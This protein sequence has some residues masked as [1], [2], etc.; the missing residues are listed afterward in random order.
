MRQLLQRNSFQ[1]SSRGTPRSSAITRSGSSAATSVTKSHSPL[2]A[3][4]ATISRASSRTWISRR[5][6]VRGVKPRLTSFRSWVCRGGSMWISCCCISRRSVSTMSALMQVP[7]SE[8]KS[9][10]SLET[11]ST[12]WWRVKTQKPRWSISTRPGA[13]WPRPLR[14]GCQWTGECSCSHAKCSC[15]TPRSKVVGSNKSICGV[16]MQLPALGHQRET[17]PVARRRF[18]RCARPRALCHFLQH[19]DRAGASEAD[20]VGEAESRIRNLAF[21]GLPAQV[22]RDFVDI[23]DAR[24][25]E[26][27]PL[28]QKP[29]GDV[30]R[31]LASERR[32]SLVDHPPGLAIF[33]KPKVLVVQDLRSREAIVQLHK[34]QLLGADPRHLVGLLRGKTGAGVDVRHHKVPIRP[35]ITR[36]HR[37]LDAHRTL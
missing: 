9:S 27:M 29:P 23:R 8:E 15:G 35:R 30:H 25:S 19:V 24:R 33:A 12:C 26:G 10:G 4:L 14:P 6:M 22:R 3:T 17:P 7:R 21:A 16:V 20:H 31:D 13:S 2:S 1:R 11:A 34:R 37:R 36:Q 28:R 32:L 5:P 18:A